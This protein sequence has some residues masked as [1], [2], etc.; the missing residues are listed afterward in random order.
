MH[1]CM[2]TECEQAIVLPCIMTLCAVEIKT[3]YFFGHNFI[4]FCPLVVNSGA[5]RSASAKP[6]ARALRS[7]KQKLRELCPKS[8]SFCPIRRTFPKVL[9]GF[10]A[11]VKAHVAAA[12]IQ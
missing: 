10:S 2:S 9:V 1:V 4:S 11:S 3:V 8:G 12:E 6:I 5:N 7:S